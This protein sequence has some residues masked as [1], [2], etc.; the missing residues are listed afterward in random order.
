MTGEP[1]TLEQRLAR[2][3]GPVWDDSRL[4][5]VITELLKVGL[6]TYLDEAALQDGDAVAVQ[7][8]A[9][10]RIS[11]ARSTDQLAEHMLPRIVVASGGTVGEPFGPDSEGLVGHTWQL[12]ISATVAGSD[13]DD[14]LLKAGSYGAAIRS[15]VS[16]HATRWNELIRL[17]EWTGSTPGSG[18]A[19]VDAEQRSIAVVEEQFL[20]QIVGVL[21]VTRELD[22]PDEEPGEEPEGPIDVGEHDVITQTELTVTLTEAE[23]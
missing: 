21:D 20:F 10:W 8:P 16:H 14:A 7:R 9:S 13:Q 22:L 17:V 18:L 1:L 15:L 3:P 11:P 4:P 23:D 12:G 2:L 6:P 19:M 5:R